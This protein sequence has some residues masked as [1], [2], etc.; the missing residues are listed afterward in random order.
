MT[1]QEGNDAAGADKFQSKNSERRSRKAGLF[2]LTAQ[3]LKIRHSVAA[4]L[5]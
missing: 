3:A 5:V 1:G 4:R 2:G